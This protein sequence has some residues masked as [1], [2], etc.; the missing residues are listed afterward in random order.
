[1]HLGAVTI[2]DGWHKVVPVSLVLSNVVSQSSKQRLVKPIQFSV[3]LRV[4]LGCFKQCA[5]HR[6]AQCC[7][8][9]GHELRF[10]VSLDYV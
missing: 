3:R 8:K 2:G 5:S 1:M 4:I 9:L 6:K 10:V 7:E